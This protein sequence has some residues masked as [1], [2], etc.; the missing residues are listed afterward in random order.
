MKNLYIASWNFEEE[1]VLKKIFL[2]L[3]IAGTMGEAAWNETEVP[4][5]LIKAD[6]QKPQASRCDHSQKTAH[7]DGE[8]H[9]V[10]V[11]VEDAC[12]EDAIA[13]Y[14]GLARVQAVET[15]D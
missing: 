11:Q 9:E 8:W 15:E 14:K 7:T 3:D 6:L 10:T 5:G 13:F 2:E 1:L 12:F 4:K